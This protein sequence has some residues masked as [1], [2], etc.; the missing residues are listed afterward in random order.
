MT[1]KY[2]FY[3]D[4]NCP[5]VDHNTILIDIRDPLDDNV[6][7]D[8]DSP[9]VSGAIPPLGITDGMSPDVALNSFAY[10]RRGGKS[11]TELRTYL[12]SLGWTYDESLSYYGD[13]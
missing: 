12:E 4:D 7:I 2:R 9:G 6:E 5:L 3:L 11:M 13:F 10:N 8:I 1:P